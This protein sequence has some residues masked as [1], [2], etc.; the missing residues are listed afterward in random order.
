MASPERFSPPANLTELSEPSGL[1][2]SKRVADI[3]EARTSAFPQF[4]NPLA[5]SEGPG[6]EPPAVVAARPVT[7]P[8]FP[9]RLRTIDDM[10]RWQMAD[11]DRDQQDEYCE[12][13]VER[14]GD[15]IVR[16]TF[17]TE[18][19]DYFDHL[20]EHD[21]ELLRKHYKDFAGKAPEN[22]EE[23]KDGKGNFDPTNRF[24]RSDDGRLV[25]LSQEDNF[26]SAAVGLV[27]A[28]T[29]LRQ[30]AN[31]ERVTA[32]DALVECG[33]FGNAARSSDP[34]IAVAVNQLVAEGKEISVADPAGLYIDEFIGA[35]LRAPDDAPAS[36]FWQVKRGDAD[37]TL[38][39]CFEVPAGRNYS[40]SEIELDGR[41]IVTG[42]QLADHV[43]VRVVALA[44]PGAHEPV[45]RRCVGED[46]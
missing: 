41:K 30:R 36:D 33:K 39:A 32:K 15:E 6:D 26:L 12:W 10:E 16:V 35:G 29:V 11:E 8:A 14:S 4:F 37:H 23:L 2:W 7:W 1:A 13:G 34:Q 27:A 20:L 45:P 43:R 46:G 21:S 25:H 28:A 19:P 3:I 40:V 18:T 9:A 44:R 38:R 24:N 22:L 5:G 31:G 42:G 17:T